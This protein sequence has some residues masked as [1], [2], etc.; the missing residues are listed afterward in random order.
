MI[1][2]LVGVLLGQIT[3]PLRTVWGKYSKVIA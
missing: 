2:V 3:Y 1:R